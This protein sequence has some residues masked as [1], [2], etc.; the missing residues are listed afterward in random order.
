MK[1]VLAFLMVAVLAMAAFAGTPSLTGKGLFNFEYQD[2]LSMKETLQYDR[3][4]LNVSDK[5]EEDGT[6]YSLKLRF[7][8]GTLSATNISFDKLIDTAYASHKVSFTDDMSLTAYFGRY[9]KSNSSYFGF[10]RN[11]SSFSSKHDGIALVFDGKSDDFSFG[12]T[13]FLYVATNEATPAV[14]ADL[15]AK[16]GYKGVTA[17]FNGTSLTEGATNMVVEANVKVVV[18]DFVELPVDV[19]LFGAYKTQD[20]FKK[21]TVNAGLKLGYEDFGFNNEFTMVMKEKEDSVMNYEGEVSYSFL[22]DYSAALYVGVPLTAKDKVYTVEPS[23]SAS[24]DKV[25]YRLYAEFELNKKDAKPKFGME[26]SFGF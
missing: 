5:S 9:R 17:H 10:W 3:F 11:Y 21:N 16:L 4:D 12:V 26:A 1:K 14:G 6:G 15:L 8:E 7:S 2:K 19:D 13:P 22:D 25:G 24:Y 23:V 18:G 20:N